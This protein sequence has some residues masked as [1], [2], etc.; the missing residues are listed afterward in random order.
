MSKPN[1]LQ[2]GRHSQDYHPAKKCH[3]TF[4]TNSNHSK[5]KLAELSQSPTR[6]QHQNCSNLR[7][8]E[9][10]IM[11]HNRPNSKCPHSKSIPSQDCPPP[12]SSTGHSIHPE[13]MGRVSHAKSTCQTHKTPFFLAG[14][15]ATAEFNPEE[16]LTL[17]KSSNVQAIFKSAY[18][19]AATL[20]RVSLQWHPPKRFPMM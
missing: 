19:S 10:N 5:P 16:M 12:S 8:A 1:P 15:V 7:I 13:A 3:S 9:C 18:L 6:S 11:K 4:H 2:S 14:I 20:A 17:Q